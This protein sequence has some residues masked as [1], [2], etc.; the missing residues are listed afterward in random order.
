MGFLRAA[1]LVAALEGCGAAGS[2]E[3]KPIPV[4]MKAMQKGFFPCSGPDWDCL[5][6]NPKALVPQ[7]TEGQVLVEMRS[8]ALNPRDV[9]CVEPICLAF[10][11]KW[12]FPFRCYHGTIGGDSILGGDGAGVIAAVGPGCPEHKVGDEVW[13]FFD[14]SFAEYALAP[15]SQVRLK[16][17]SLNFIDAGTI[18]GAGNT[19]VDIFKRTGAPW[20]SSDNITVVVT[21]G[22][23][24]TGFIAVQVAKALGAA[25]VVTAASG[26]GL[27]L[28]KSLGVDIVVDY[29]KQD[30]FDVLGDDSMDVVFDNIGAAGTADKAMPSIRPGGTFMLLTGGGKGKLSKHPKRGVTQ[31]ESGIF[32]PSGEALDALAGWF[33]SGALRPH[34]F[35]TFGLPEVPAAFNQILGHGI[36]GK[37]AI[38]PD[39]ALADEPVDVLV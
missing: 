12:G 28:M 29:H 24:G 19:A 4:N 5:S 6:L 2:G 33:D 3:H 26:A 10:R 14:G 17:K 9:D 18:P 34:T 11:L 37:M 8:A 38:V 35:Q 39:K 15:C 21:A 16:P 30:L 7:Q 20:K 31:I 27:D 25:R 36:I 1:A 13:G 22:Q 32:N 23:G